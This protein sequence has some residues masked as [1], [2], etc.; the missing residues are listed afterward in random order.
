M[1][2]KSCG[3]GGKRFSGIPILD[4]NNKVLAENYA[5]YRGLPKTRPKSRVRLLKSDKANVNK[6]LYANLTNI[7]FEGKRINVLDYDK[8]NKCIYVVGY[9]EGCGSCNYMKRL[10]NK[11]MTPEISARVHTYT[12]DKNITEPTGFQFAGNPTILFVDQ[13][14]LVFQVGGIYN[15]IWDKIVS[16]YMQ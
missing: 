11:L 4:A 5:E 10:L 8:K 2:C 6:N 12:L 14:K 3:S 9:M 13:G 16:Y 15:K 1:G 7:Q